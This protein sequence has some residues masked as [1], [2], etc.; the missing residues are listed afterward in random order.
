VQ[1]D[2]LGRQSAACLLAGQDCTGGKS[3]RE[4]GQGILKTQKGLDLFERVTTTTATLRKTD[5]SVANLFAG[6]LQVKAEEGGVEKLVRAS[7]NP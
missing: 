1:H 7:K 6:S 4:A 5:I 2:D 3:G